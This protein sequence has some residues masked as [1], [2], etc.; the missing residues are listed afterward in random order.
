MR[1]FYLLLSN[2]CNIRFLSFSIRH[3]FLFPKLKLKCVAQKYIQEVLNALVLTTLLY[4]TQFFPLNEHQVYFYVTSPG[5]STLPRWER[6]TR[7]FM[8][9]NQK[10]WLMQ[11]VSSL[12]LNSNQ[13]CLH[14]RYLR[15]KC[16]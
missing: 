2:H 6:Q 9:S 16:I 7:G 1:N 15:G 5:I 4:K 11:S 14:C 10:S 8:F 3:W 13:I 12:G